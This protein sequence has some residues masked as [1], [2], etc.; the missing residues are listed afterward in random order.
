MTQSRNLSRRLLL[1]G[2]GG[3]AVGL[4]LLQFNS[5]KAFAA[6]T[7][8]V[9]KRFVVFFEH[10]GTIS[11]SDRWGSRYDGTGQESGDDAWKP[12]DPGEALVLGPI[13]QPLIDHLDSLLVLRG[14]DNKA[15]LEQ[16]PYNGSHG[17]ANVTALT[18]GRAS[19][20]EGG[21]DQATSESP[22]IDAVLA[23]RLAERN[24]VRFAAVNLEASAHNYGTPFFRAARQPFD[25][26]SNPS[27]AFENIFAGVSAT[28]SGPDPVVLRARALKKSILDGT[29]EG[30]SLLKTRIGAQDRLTVEAHLE[31]IRTLE[32]RLAAAA[33]PVSAGCILPN[34]P[35]PE[36]NFNS[37]EFSGPAH[38]DLMIAALRCGL[39]NVVTL[40]IGDME[41]GWLNPPYQAG[42]GIGHS[43]HHAAGDVGPQGIE[44]HL[45]NDWYKSMLDNRV[46]RMG[47]LKQFMDAL[48]VT[49]ED[50]GSMLD[51]TVI[52]WTS[53]FSRG[54]DHSSADV[55]I[56]LAGKAGHRFRTGRHLNY[57]LKAAANPD[58]LDYETKASTH[59]LFT[60]I[61]NVFDYPDTHFG[62]EHAP[63]Q[64]PLAGLT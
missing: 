29:D 60:S 27:T 5:G 9:P 11:P 23:T 30:L 3:L 39:T 28:G 38:V 53:E 21:H 46:W 7:P 61:L 31:H 16:A 22:S 49:P 14:I 56:L 32:R 42:Y 58:T 57:N 48:A 59:N 24:P 18:A 33:T 36:F 51:N 55:P 54:V 17:W 40:N 35:D 25:G 62:S 10:G 37:T 64:G 13:H 26:E 50:D 43:L 45:Y 34:Q 41:T 20:L 1:R 4:P 63:V 47:L 2:L 44:A 52:L 6:G 12:A 19:A 8:R 15:C